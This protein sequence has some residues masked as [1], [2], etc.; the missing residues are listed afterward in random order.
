MSDWAC[1]LA[2]L[3]CFACGALFGWSI[4]NAND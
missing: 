3:V 1:A 2:V 4:N